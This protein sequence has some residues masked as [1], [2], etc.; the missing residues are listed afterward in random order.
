MR[1]LL[2]LA[3]VLLSYL[4]YAQNGN[5]STVRNTFNRETTVAI[6]IQAPPEKVWAILTDASDYPNWNSTVISITGDI[7][8][9]EKIVLESTLDPERQFKLKVKEFEAPTRLVWGDGKGTRTYTIEAN[10]RGSHTFSM[11]EKIGGLM[12]PMYAKYIPDF[13]DS[14]EAF[15][16]DLKNE[17]EK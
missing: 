13:D 6:D 3:T 7:A 11:T 4:P 16:R 15:A 17:A 14:F 1:Y 10:D 2:V 8:E 5:A 12:F 9:G